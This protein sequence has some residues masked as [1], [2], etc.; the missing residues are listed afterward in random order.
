MANEN[1]EILV[2]VFDGEN[3]AKE[4]LAAMAE[5]S[6]SDVGAIRDYLAV[7]SRDEQGKLSVSRPKKQAGQSALAGALI[8]ALAGTAT[9]LPVIGTVVGGAAGAWRATHKKKSGHDFSLERLTELMTPNSSVIV[10][11]IEDW[12]VESVISN[13]EMRGAKQV[14]RVD[15]TELGQND[16]DTRES[17]GRDA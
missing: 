1:I 11:E 17:S 8:G 16:A 9:G 6:T 4:V 13:L 12:R 7:I 3:R 2:A 10:A 5:A 15:E 14:M